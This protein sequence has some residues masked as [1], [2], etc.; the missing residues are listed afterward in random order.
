MVWPKESNLDDFEK[1]ELQPGEVWEKAEA[2][3]I[4]LTKPTSLLNR[5][6]VWTFKAR[7]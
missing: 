1:E 3:M 6:K 4:Q 5:L 7:W 2:Y